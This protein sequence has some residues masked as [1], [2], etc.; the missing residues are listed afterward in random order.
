MNNAP[1]FIHSLF[2]SGSTFLFKVFRR[3]AAGY[4]CY[5][6][7]LHE[8]VVDANEDPQRL[9]H[10]RGDDLVRELR[11]PSLDANYFHE[12]VEVWPAWK[13]VLPGG[14]VYDAYFSPPGQ[15]I[16]I[17]YLRTLINAAKGRPVFQDCRTSGR[18]RE[19]RQALNGFHIYLWR[20]PW[21]QWWSY[22]VS[23]Y[24]K[25][26]NLLI[27]NAPYLPKAVRTLVE[28]L[29]IENWSHEGVAEGVANYWNKTLTSEQSYLIFYLLWCL[30]L[31]EGMAHADL[32]L[33][34][35]RLSDSAVCQAENSAL[36]KAAGIAGIDFSDC[37][38]PQ[39]RYSEKEQAFFHAL[40]ERVHRW[41]M[42]DGWSPPEIERMQALRRQCQ[43]ENWGAG[44]E[45]LAPGALCEQASRARELTIRFETM[46]AERIRDDALRVSEA[47]LQARQ[48]EVMVRQAEANSQQAEVRAEHAQAKAQQEEARAR[49]AEADRQQAE[50]QARQAEA[51]LRQ[52]EARARQA[53]AEARQAE[54][55]AGQAE[56]RAQ[57][58]EAKAHQAQARTL[59]AEAN[60]RQAQAKAEQAE[61]KALQAQ[62]ATE[63]AR[64]RLLAVYASASWRFTAPFRSLSRFLKSSHP[65]PRA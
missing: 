59:H 53:E 15:D 4:W 46:L 23:E 33:N 42:D 6:E 45:K 19:I 28:E 1:I 51:K 58:E 57:Q 40:E 29:H 37:S 8:A 20:N 7:P 63:Q 13:D 50:V 38:V 49:Q 52:A 24:F 62:A 39:G 18:L 55:R 44:I 32:M 10:D 2:R 9:L 54:A 65:D 30:G 43:P 60:A 5:Q 3:S 21:D 35:D 41:L 14:A 26:A 11:H 34:I 31:R 61:E 47:E 16:G 64:S 36:L 27:I 56:A 22:K 17:A 25:A 12:L 48:A